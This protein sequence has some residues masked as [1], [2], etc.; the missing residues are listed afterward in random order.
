MSDSLA[1]FQRGFS[2]ALLG[3]GGAPTALATQRGFAVYR[4]TVLEGWIDALEANY[5]AVARLVGRDW[6]RSA[7]ALHARADPPRDPRLLLYGADF[8]TFL[9]GFA[10][11]AGLPYLA[12][13]ARLD[14]FWTE[15]HVAAD[16]PS[17]DAAL[18]ARLPAEALG[19]TVLRPHPATRWAWFEDQPIVSIWMRN[20]ADAND[21]ATPEELVW[22]G[23]GVLLA[24]PVGAVA[25]GPLGRGGCAFLD[26]CAKGRPLAEAAQVALAAENGV[27]LAGLLSHLLQRGALH[28]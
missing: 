10:P 8:A 25:W 5:P 21:G 2:D 9:Q 20:R 14:R 24:R 7:A 17:A 19:A 22:R 18:L 11:A 12:A 23:E 28:S 26:A 16:A 4:N 13:V 27:D 3:R 15:S 1:A 6:F